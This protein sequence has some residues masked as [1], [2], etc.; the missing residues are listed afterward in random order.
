M[1][2]V[3]LTGSIGMGK[4]T[5]AERFRAH[6]IGVCDADAEVHKLYEGAAAD[7][8]ERAFPGT[9]AGGRVDRNKLSAALLR[10]PAGFK[11]LEAIVHP[12]VE[13]AEREFLH[14]E[15]SRGAGIAVLEIPLLF[16]IGRDAQLDVTI[17]VSAPAS[18]QRQRVL[19][20]PGMTPEKLDA[21]L[22]RQ[23]PDAE[24]RRRAD[25][26]VDTGLPIEQSLA[27][28]DAIIA[29]L[30]NREAT[31]YCRFWA[32]L[33]AGTEGRGEPNAARDRPRYGDD[34]P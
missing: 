25:F 30:Q 9:T 29:L 19:Q 34:G 6:G 24:K 4:S 1:L 14:C 16:E 5:V 26:V 3:G 27:Q 31:A 12:L 11:R 33:T 2:V 13:A 10:D 8:I 28:V 22:A 7:P 17:M 20:R 21:I 18:V 32:G 23:M 15:W